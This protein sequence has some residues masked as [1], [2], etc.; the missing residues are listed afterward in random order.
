VLKDVIRF[1]W[2]YHTRQVS[3][4]AAA[5][6]F[7]GFGFALTAT[8]FGPANVH[9]NSPYDIAQ[10]LGM[11]SLAAIF[12]LLQ[13]IDDVTPPAYRPLVAEWTRDVI[14]YDL[15][16]TAATA[17][18]LPDGRFEVTMQVVAHK[19]RD[20]EREVPLDEPIEIG[21]FT[22]DPDDAA[23][24]DIVHLAAHRLHSGANTVTV[25]VAKQPA[26]AAIDPYITRSIAI[27][28]TT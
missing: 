8:G 2:R 23:A 27:A 14:L 11:V 20:D 15:T 4:F 19:S 10:S 3:F 21:I 18:R 17:H 16:M 24:D 12:D 6:F 25:I 9:I 28:S 5:L 26:F 22:A 13:S 1:E 7:A